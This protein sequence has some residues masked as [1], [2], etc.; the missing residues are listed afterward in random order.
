MA[1]A[2]HDL[3]FVN[4][5][6]AREQGQWLGRAFVSNALYL[7]PEEADWSRALDALLFIH[8]QEPRRRMR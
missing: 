3:A 4:L 1:A 8:T 2:G 7:V 6:R 5:R